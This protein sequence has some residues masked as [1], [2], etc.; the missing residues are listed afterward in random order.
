[1][2]L[3]AQFS[4]PIFAIWAGMKPISSRLTSLGLFVFVMALSGFSVESR[5]ANQCRAL[6]SGAGK[7]VLP[8]ERVV[9]DVGPRLTNTS[10][11]Y[12]GKY[13]GQHRGIV[14]G[15]HDLMVV[16][17]DATAERL[18]LNPNGIDIPL[19]QKQTEVD[20]CLP[21]ALAYVQ[22][23]A[24]DQNS[25]VARFDERTRAAAMTPFISPSR[26]D[27]WG[28]SRIWSPYS[29]AVNMGQVNGINMALNAAGV[30]YREVRSTEEV[31]AALKNGNKV[32]IGASVNGDVMRIYD[33]QGESTHANVA[34]PSS[35]GRAGHAMV[36]VKVVPGE[37]G[38]LIYFAD[39]ASG[40]LVAV[41]DTDQRVDGIQLAYVID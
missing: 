31:I 23:H 6:F 30:K 3:D 40:E 9:I 2:H 4:G 36:A 21:T 37:G 24:G 35:S 28:V 18:N 16:I 15:S 26:L 32:L 22:S 41:K 12:L 39:P 1:M 10:I 27:P 17:S 38:H 8:G 7:T 29:I 33:E 34:V 11:V 25:I 14:A 20:N 13:G 5:A 19:I